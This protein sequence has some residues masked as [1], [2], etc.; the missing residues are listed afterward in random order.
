[1]SRIGRQA[2]PSAKATGTRSTSSMKNTPNRIERPP[3]AARP[4]DI[5]RPSTPRARA[6]RADRRRQHAAPPGTAARSTPAT[7]QAM[8]ISHIGSSASSEIRSQAKCVNSMPHHTKTSAKISTTRRETMRT[9]ALA[10][11]SAARR[12]PRNACPRARRASR[13]HDHPDEAESA[14]SPRSRCR[15]GSVGVA[16][17]DLQRDRDD[18][19]RRP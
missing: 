6:R 11:A 4:G 1:M 16:R 13:R 12:R 8:W 18:Q 2:R 7:G 14:P 19:D 3:V 5:A 17:E 15:T 9:S 10:A